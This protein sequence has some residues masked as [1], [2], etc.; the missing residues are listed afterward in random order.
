MRLVLL[1]LIVLGC[2]APSCQPT[3]TPAPPPAPTTAPVPVV[4]DAGTPCANACSS[5][6]LSCAKPLLTQDVCVFR[7]TEGMANLTGM[8]PA[9]FASVAVCNGKVGCR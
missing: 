2:A 1:A 8:T 9:C 7:C 5:A 4:A 3:P 6:I